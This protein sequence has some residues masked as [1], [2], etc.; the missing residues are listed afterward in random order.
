MSNTLTTLAAIVKEMFPSDALGSTLLEGSALYAE[1]PKDWAAHGEPIRLATKYAS[2]AG[3]ASTFADAQ[4]TIG[5]VAMSRWEL[6]AVREYSLFRVD[7]M[8]V[9]ACKGNKGALVDALELAG[10]NALGRLKRN[11][12]RSLYR[13]FGGAVATVGSTAALEL[14]LDN[15]ED[16]VHFSVGDVIASDNTDG[17]AGGTDDGEYV[18]ITEVDEDTGILTRAGANWTA[19][20]NFA[21]ADSLFFRGTFGLKLSG[22]ASWLPAAAPGATA[23]FGV[24]RSVNPTKLGGIRFVADIA[25]H[26]TIEGTLVAAGG[27]AQRGGAKPTHVFMNPLDHAQLV[28]E[29]GDRVRYEKVAPTGSKGMKIQGHI[30]F[31]ALI[32]GTATGPVKVMIDVD[33][34]YGVAYMLDMK[35]W[36]LVGYGEPGWLKDDGMEVLRQADGD[37]YEGRMG[38]YWQMGCT[39]PGHNVRIDLSAVQ[40]A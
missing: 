8:A 9:R 1:M 36:K 31:D 11:M 12:H 20:G 2:G 22:L 17:T 16:V 15:I 7:G 23:F 3:S 27:R 33:C 32:L 26:Q 37:S 24:N 34:P 30:G 10:D 35:T 28:R 4:A 25:L 13:D 40:V 14:T 38:C 21:N 29:L 19:G 6:S 18:T 39:A 5:S